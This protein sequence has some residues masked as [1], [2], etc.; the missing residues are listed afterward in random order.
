MPSM[1]DHVADK[2]GAEL[3]RL[4]KLYDFPA[5]VKQA[6]PDQTL[7]PG[8]LPTHLYADVVRQQFPCHTAASTWLSAL[9]FTEK[10]AEF[11]PKDQAQIQKRLDHYTGYWRI[12]PAVDAIVARWQ[13]LHKTA[14]EQLPDHMFAYVWV[15]DDGRKERHLRLSNAMEVK[16]AAEY[17]EAYRDRFPFSVRHVMAGKILEKAARHGAGIARHV[18]FLERQA[19]R[20][21]CDPAEVV[22]LVEDRARLAPHTDADAYKAAADEQDPRPP[23]LR[24]QFL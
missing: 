17:V 12:K 5:F 18:E 21:V 8:R 2:S 10:R 13:A 20:G 24:Q 1:M 19:G 14:E 23:S 16:A 7:N 3:V 9:Y 22:A 15:G 4:E 6:N 11:H